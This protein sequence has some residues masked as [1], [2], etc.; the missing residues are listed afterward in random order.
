[1]SFA[2][3]V[4]LLALILPVSQV[5]AEQN[6][7]ESLV[8]TEIPAFQCDTLSRGSLTKDGIAQLKN[9]VKKRINTA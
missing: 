1:M 9:C 2:I 8:G 7:L 3:K 6:S 4:A 5:W